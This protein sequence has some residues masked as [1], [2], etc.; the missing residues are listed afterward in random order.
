EG[1]LGT[2]EMLYMPRGYW[3]AT[4]FLNDPSLHLT[5]AVQHPSGM[6]Y[7]GW[8]AT[9]L[10]ADALARRDMPLPVFDIPDL[11]DQAQD[12]Y[13]NAMRE[14]ITRSVS[15]ASLA[16]FL[17]EYRSTL[18]TTNHIRLNA[19]ERRIDGKQND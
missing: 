16:R 1:V 8:L 3:H 10:V 6:Q 12:D 17:S 14:L 9:E 18:G 5:F 15:K 2:G 13:L 19:S 4:R 11:G 7:A